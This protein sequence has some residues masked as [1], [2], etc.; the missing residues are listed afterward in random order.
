[1]KIKKINIIY[2][3]ITEKG[4]SGGG[5]IIY[6]HS[7]VINKLGNQSSSQVLHVKKKRSRK[8]IISLSKIFT[9][10]E[11]KY[12]GWKFNDITVK[13][14][15][16]SKWFNS[17]INIKNDFNFDKNRDFIIIPEIFAHF[18]NDLC[19]KK[20][21]S[22]AIFVQNGYCLKPTNDYQS[23]NRAYKNAKFILSYSNDITRCI[24]TAFPFCNNKIQETKYSIDKE[25][26]NFSTKKVNMIT[27]MPRKLPD[28]ASH[29]IFF[30]R[31]YLPKKWK[32]KAI[33]NLEEKEV[34][35]YLLKSK[36]FLAF[37]K[38]E[39]LGLPPIEAAIA[40]NKVIG[41]SGEGGREY[42]KKPVFKEINN[43][44]F[45]KFSHEILKSIKNDERRN[46]RF[47]SARKK[48]INQFSTKSEIVK[49]KNMLN[50]IYSFF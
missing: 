31:N 12:S 21:I 5:K 1:M 25:D 39:G 37:S 30:L 19:I 36:I 43:G 28:H 13:K 20:R 48:L 42:W 10:M 47:I 34:Y 11:P 44:D 4:P 27:Y 50:K 9:N 46:K 41:Y 33:H 2:I 45:A 40:G 23:L 16:K 17:N 6:K 7:D 32:I 22:Y 8:W 18:A 15:Y 49:I 14:N 24:K 29:L 26:F 38:L 35:K 3:C